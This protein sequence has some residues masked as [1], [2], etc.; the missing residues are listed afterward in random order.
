MASSTATSG[1]LVG[2]RYRLI[3]PL[4]S[5]GM[6]RVYLAEDQRL[7]RRVAVKLLD[8]AFDDRGRR[9]TDRLE[10]EAERAAA[11]SHP[12]VVQV[13][14]VGRHEGRA[15]LVMEHVEGQTLD[16]LLRQR[17]PLADDEIIRIG[18]DVCAALAAI[19]ERGIQHR[20]VKPANIL[21]SDDRVRLVDFGI[22]RGDAQD[23]LTEEAL[24]GS[25]PYVSPEQAS[26]TDADHRADLYGL[27]VVLYELAT[28]QPPFLGDTL[29][30]TVL[31]R[32]VRDPDP[33]SSL[34]DVSP[35][36]ESVIMTGLQRDPA[37][38][39]DDAG[40]M[41]AALRSADRGTGTRELPRAAVRRGTRRLVLPVLVAAMAL[42]VLAAW[43]PTAPITDVTIPDLTGLSLPAAERLLAADGLTVGTVHRI[44]ASEPAGQVVGQRPYAGT[45]ASEGQAI[46]VYVSR[47]SVP[48][49]PDESFEVTS[50]GSDASQPAGGSDAGGDSG[51]GTA[52]GDD[53]GRSQHAPGR[54]DADP[55]GKDGDPPPGQR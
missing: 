54:S 51:E 26:G 5:G 10:R 39:F 7:R 28:G 35:R 22:A 16:D 50:D 33:P 53:T 32:T 36:L 40:E 44:A 11:L 21:V 31:M 4:G 20:D 9:G 45:D 6:A 43:P 29:A 18:I 41:A 52:P 3:E 42:I 49:L 13:H 27:A 15:Y 24:M 19:H 2:G 48:G 12:N 25:A 37:A 23:T 46:D 34:A 47:G 1:T 30:A 55:P 17:G 8:P 38:R 14:D